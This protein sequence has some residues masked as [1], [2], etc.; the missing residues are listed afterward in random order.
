MSNPCSGVDREADLEQKH[1]DEAQLP[2]DQGVHQPS[3][4]T[5]S[6]SFTDDSLDTEA[7]APSFPRP[8][9]PDRLQAVL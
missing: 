5:H 3:E 1:R 9:T 4:L 6:G 7:I 2:Q 8:W